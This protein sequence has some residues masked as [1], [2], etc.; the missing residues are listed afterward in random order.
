MNKLQYFG[1]LI[2]VTFFGIQSLFS[3][4]STKNSLKKGSWSLQ[5]QISNNFTLDEF[6]GSTISAK[7]HFS[8]NSALRFGIGLTSVSTDD[9]YTSSEIYNYS[10][11]GEG[12]REY[13][14]NII[15]FNFY[16]LY[17]PN[18]EK[19]LNFY[20]GGGPSIGYSDYDDVQNST[21]VNQDTIFIETT[22]N[23]EINS[24]SIGIHG[25]LGVEWFV[26]RSISIHAEY[27]S[28]FTYEQEERE[29]TSLR[30]STN[31][32]DNKRTLKTDKSGFELRANGV[33]FGLSVYF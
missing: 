23:N 17:Y 10:S 11:F 33:K 26:N 24:Y 6:Q 31:H 7:R 29:L 3:Q 25:L 20:F 14:Y 15:E 1:S 2:L 22:Y 28:S 18:P 21:E 4:D 32:E 13:T 8:S 30:T 5:F 12:K 9:E 19:K 16:Y 27:L